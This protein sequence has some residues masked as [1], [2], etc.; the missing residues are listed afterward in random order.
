[1]VSVAPAYVNGL[2]DRRAAILRDEDGR[3]TSGSG[4]RM[5]V[6]DSDRDAAVLDRLLMASSSARIAG[7]L[8]ERR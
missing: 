2:S 5:K 8:G 7:L 3:R 6:L 4:V 1:M